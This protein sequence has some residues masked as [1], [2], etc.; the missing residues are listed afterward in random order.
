M[1]NLHDNSQKDTSKGKN[2]NKIDAE[3]MQKN[4]MFFRRFQKAKRTLKVQDSQEFTQIMNQSYGYEKFKPVHEFLRQRILESRKQR[5]NFR[6]SMGY[7][8][9]ILNTNEKDKIAIKQQLHNKTS[10]DPQENI[11]SK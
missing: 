2:F 9:V 5:N 3:F 8:D 11:E 7:D 10:E 4:A 6:R 1:D